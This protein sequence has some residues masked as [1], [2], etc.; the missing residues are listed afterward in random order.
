M[1]NISTLHIYLKH[2]PLKPLTKP[3]GKLSYQSEGEPFNFFFAFYLI[4]RIANKLTSCFR[5]Q[6]PE[7]QCQ[8]KSCNTVFLCA[9]KT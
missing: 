3:A 1:P 4:I 9:A 5:F 6:V 8:E 2:I 7:W